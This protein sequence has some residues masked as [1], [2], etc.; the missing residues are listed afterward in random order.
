VRGFG[1]GIG[2]TN[3]AAALTGS[4]YNPPPDQVGGRL[5]PATGEVEQPLTNPRHPLISRAMMIVARI[6]LN[7]RR[8]RSAAGDRV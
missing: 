4:L 5:S 2:L 6:A 1:Q 8:S 7:R 3:S